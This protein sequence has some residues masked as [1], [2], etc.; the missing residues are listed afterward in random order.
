M[1]K[2]KSLLPTSKSKSLT[3]KQSTPEFTHTTIVPKPKSKHSRPPNAPR[4]LLIGGGSRGAAIAQAIDEGTDG[5]LVSIA[6]PDPGRRREIGR[7][8]IWKDGEVKEGMEWADWRGFL[9]CE[10]QRR[11]GREAASSTEANRETEDESGEGSGVTIDAVII[12]TPDRT[13]REII[14]ALAPLGLHIMCE[15]PLATSMDDCVAISRGLA[16][17]LQSANVDLEGSATSGPGALFAIGHVMRYAPINQLIRQLIFEEG[18]VGD[19]VSIEHTENVGWWHFAHSYARGN[20]RNAQTSGPTLLTKSCH[21]IDFFMWLLCTPSPTP[22]GKPHTPSIVASFGSVS[23]FKRAR[24]PTAAGNAT[25]CLSCPAEKDCHF[26]AKRIY[27]DKGLK[28]G[29][30][31]WPVNVAVP[32]I[33]DIIKEGGM[34]AAEKELLRKLEEDYTPETPAHVIDGKQWYGRCVYESDNNVCDDQTVHIIWE[35]DTITLPDGTST[36]RP[37]K[38]ATLHMT[39]FAEGICTKRTRILG[40]KGEIERRGGVLAVCD[41]T[42][43]KFYEKRPPLS[44]GG[45]GGGDHGLMKAFVSAVDAVKNKGMAVDEAQVQFIGCGVEDIV[46]SH[47]VVFAAEEARVERKIVDWDEWW[48]ENV[49]D[50]HG[51]ISET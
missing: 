51:D 38:S 40:T 30:G 1:N 26:S 27:L 23:H 6:D 9:E 17:P 46:R 7:R 32:D 47:A 25:N 22:G 10:L 13:H 12:A 43:G 24:K 4:L 8:F 36:T 45:H 14:T 15:K 20:W 19:I 42:T 5:I 35:D 48:R 34:V 28:M 29:L 44:I 16:V 41:F 39:A 49:L 33:E 21:D 18:V 2:L 37:S 31:G 11:E 50:S 3:R